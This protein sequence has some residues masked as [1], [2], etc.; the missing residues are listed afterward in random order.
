MRAMNLQ[1]DEREVRLVLTKDK[2]TELNVTITPIKLTPGIPFYEDFTDEPIDEYRIG[3]Q[4]C[5]RTAYAVV[6]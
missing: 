5:M 1:E 3:L 2:I 6:S 4:N